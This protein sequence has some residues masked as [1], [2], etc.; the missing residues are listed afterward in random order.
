MK[1]TFCVDFFFLKG[2]LEGE[3]YDNRTSNV[4]GV[5]RIT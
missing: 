2:R 1:S 5:S 3:N 4:G